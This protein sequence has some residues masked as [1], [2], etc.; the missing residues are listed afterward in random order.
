M[1]FNINVK[2]IRE[3]AYDYQY[4]KQRFLMHSYK[5]VRSLAYYTTICFVCIYLFLPIIVDTT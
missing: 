2:H 3:Y 4:I 5:I 1:V